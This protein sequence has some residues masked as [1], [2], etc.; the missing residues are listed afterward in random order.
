MKLKIHLKEI[1]MRL[2]L[3][4]NTI[5]EIRISRWTR[6]NVSWKRFFKRL[7]AIVACD[8]IGDEHFISLP[9]F[10]SILCPRFSILKYVRKRE[11]CSIKL[12]CL[13]TLNNDRI[14]L[15]LT[16]RYQSF[17]VTVGDLCF[18]SRLSYSVVGRI[19]DFFSQRLPWWRNGI[20]DR[21]QSDRRH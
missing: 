5:S 21:Y 11:D 14:K 12:N 17:G 19:L 10:W 4:S 3:G 15:Y 18:V 20:P 9:S 1:Q 16:D 8:I 6:L 2:K 7:Y 13:M